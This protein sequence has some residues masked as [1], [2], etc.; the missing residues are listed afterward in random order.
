[1]AAARVDR[2]ATIDEIARPELQPG[3][4]EARLQ[5]DRAGRRIYLIVDQVDRTGV[6]HGLIV[7][8]ERG[9]RG[10]RLPERQPSLSDDAGRDSENDRDRL[11]LSDYYD[12]V[13]I[14]GSEKI[15]LVD[16][17]NPKPA[18]DR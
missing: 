10:S 5:L 18:V 8:G 12:R 2:D 15:A 3:I 4:R 13:G 6:E 9:N 11:Q 14:G 17:A 1:A 16:L 7:G